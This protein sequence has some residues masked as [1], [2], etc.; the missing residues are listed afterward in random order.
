MN[1]SIKALEFYASAMEAERDTLSKRLVRVEKRLKRTQTYWNSTCEVV[2]KLRDDK[3]AITASKSAIET[4]LKDVKCQISQLQEK[5]AH[6]NR[7][8]KTTE[9]KLAEKQRNRKAE[10]EMAQLRGEVANYF[11]Q[12]TAAKKEAD[13]AKETCKKLA[14]ANQSYESGR[15]KGNERIKQLELELANIQAIQMNEDFAKSEIEKS[16]WIEVRGN[17]LWDKDW[18][19]C[20]SKPGVRNITIAI[21]D[22]KQTLTTCPVLLSAI[23]WW[24]FHKFGS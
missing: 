2:G 17:E 22:G 10:G 5:N 7:V 6:L 15:L 24:A 18:G 4:Q 14:T 16:G 3:A 8:L 9:D 20:I 13:E 12:A 21:R 19:V 23:A 1:T 11:R